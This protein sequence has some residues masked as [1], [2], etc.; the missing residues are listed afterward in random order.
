[1][2]NYWRVY[3]RAFFCC[4][5]SLFFWK[6]YKSKQNYW[7]FNLFLLEVGGICPFAPWFY[8]SY[9]PFLL[10][11]TWLCHLCH[12]GFQAHYF[13]MFRFKFL[14]PLRF[15][16]IWFQLTRNFDY[17]KVLLPIILIGEATANWNSL[18]EIVSVKT[19]LPYN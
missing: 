4:F 6:P 7:L 18:W 14:L 11:M 19:T 13:L 2:F 15:V 3:P 10:M 12:L 8:T 9:Y 16:R 5:M 1:L 17:L